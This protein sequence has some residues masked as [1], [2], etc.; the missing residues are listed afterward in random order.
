MILGRDMK[1]INSNADGDSD[2]WTKRQRYIQCKENAWKRWKHEYLVTL[3]ERHNLSH[4]DRKRKV[5]IDDIV[6]IK[7]EWKNR[8]HWK[9]GK[10]SQLYTGKDEV[11]RAVQM[12]VGTKFLV[13]PIQLLYPLELHCDVPAREGKEQEESNLN[14][15]AK[16]FRPRRNADARIQD[17]NATNDDESKNLII[18]LSNGGSMSQIMGWPSRK[19]DLVENLNLCAIEVIVIN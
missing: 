10:V 1:T 11:V 18:T 8:G 9:I 6:M 16:E 19:S 2:E 5:K 3:R 15:D 4:K 14:A 7:G 12:Q 17:I 13:R